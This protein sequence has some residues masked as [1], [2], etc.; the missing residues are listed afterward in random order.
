MNLKFIDAPQPAAKQDYEDAVDFISGNLKKSKNII[1]II[2]F[3][4]FTTPGISDIDLMVV[5]KNNSFCNE[6]PFLDLP[7]QQRRLFTHG[8]DSITENHFINL[9]KFSLL[10]NMK[11]IYGNKELPD[12]YRHSHVELT[13][14]RKQIALEYL[15]TNYVNLTIQLN[16]KTIKIR[17]LLQHLKGL[18]YDFE[19]LN[20]KPPVL[21]EMVAELR[22]WIK[23]WFTPKQPDNKKL[24]QFIETFYI[25]YKEFL[26]E[27]FQS[28]PIYSGNKNAFRF[29]KNIQINPSSSLQHK[30]KGIVLPPSVFFG[31]KY[32][33]LNNKLNKWTFFFPAYFLTG[34]KILEQR[35]LF[36]KEYKAYSKLHFP[37]FHSLTTGII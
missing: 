33:K 30:R 36:F 11:V 9:Y 25:H 28:F 18:H 7:V 13:A 5:F 3:G 14:L 8:V 34:E 31:K 10:P 1:S 16:Y 24:A 35:Y 20:T 15:F 6:Q 22:Q 26:H 17:S 29:S 32:Y 19:F 4:N 2:R 21:Y 27:L 23:D 37:F 12:P